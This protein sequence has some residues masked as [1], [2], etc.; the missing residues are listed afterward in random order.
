M[1]CSNKVQRIVVIYVCPRAGFTS[2]TIKN[3]VI[4]VGSFFSQQECLNKEIF[5]CNL[6]NVDQRVP[7]THF[8]N[9]TVFFDSPDVYITQEYQY[10][11]R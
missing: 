11:P 8:E 6:S 4:K 7:H 5:W 2:V 9:S 1:P 10:G 3:D